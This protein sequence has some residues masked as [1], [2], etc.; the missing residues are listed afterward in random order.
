NAISLVVLGA[1]SSLQLGDSVTYHQA[2]FTLTL[3]VG[4]FQVLIYFLKLGDL[5][6]YVSESVIL[7]FM[8]G[9]GLLVALSQIPNLLA[10]PLIGHSEQPLIWRLV[11]S[12]GA[13]TPQPLALAI[14][15]GTAGLTVGLR[16]LGNRLGF[17]LPDMLLALIVASLVAQACG[18]S[19]KPIIVPP[20]LPA[21]SIP[22]VEWGWIRPLAGSA[23][24]IALLGLLEAIAIAKSIAA[25]TREKLDYNTQC[26]AEGIANLAGGLFQGIPGSGSLTRSAINYQAGARTRWSGVIAAVVVAGCLLTVADLAQYVPRPA[27]A[28]LLLVTAWR[29]VD[30][31]RLAYSLRALGY[32]RWLVLGTASAAVFISIEFSILIGVFLSFVLFVPRAARLIVTHFVV[33]PGRVVRERQPADPECDRLVILGLE[34]ELFFGAGPELEAV[35]NRLRERPQV[36][37][38]VLRLKRARNPDMV[39]LELLQHFLEDMAQR[40]VVVLLC[41]VRADLAAALRR[42]RFHHWLPEDRVFLEKTADEPA[43][44]S[45]LRAVRRAYEL[46]GEDRCAHCPRRQEMEPANPSDPSWSYMI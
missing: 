17:P 2:V 26:L 39:C 32:D 19:E 31:P 45:T 10:I 35:F 18:W 21:F 14:G 5:T 8:L 12:V 7:G 43:M 28:G 23:A 11:E 44:T 20:G 13:A 1:I 3:L 42:L 27:L 36:R 22:Q 9:A 37:V 30:R 4:L 6:R 33:S 34:G 46:L 40:G 41:G 15:L 25:R 16:G 24:A 29:L 38:V